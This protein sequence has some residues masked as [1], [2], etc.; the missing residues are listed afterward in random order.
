MVK[1]F[2]QLCR[3]IPLEFRMGQFKYIQS[4][5]NF[6]EKV[7]FPIFPELVYCLLKALLFLISDSHCSAT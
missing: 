7:R 6:Q 1:K 2:N 3:T 5:F 4:L